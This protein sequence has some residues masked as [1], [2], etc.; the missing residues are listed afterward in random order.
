MI[1]NFLKTWYWYI[2]KAVL[3]NG[4]VLIKLIWKSSLSLTGIDGESQ[5]KGS[6]SG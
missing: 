3:G 5:R 6:V 2:S 4:A 1:G